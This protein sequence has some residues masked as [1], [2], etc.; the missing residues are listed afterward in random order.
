MLGKV[1]AEEKAKN[2]RKGRQE[3]LGS[4]GTEETIPGSKSRGIRGAG[5]PGANRRPLQR[6]WTT[7]RRAASTAIPLFALLKYRCPNARTL[8]VD[9]YRV[10]RVD[11]DLDGKNRAHLSGPLLRANYKRI[12]DER[13]REDELA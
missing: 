12:F 4:E 7:H 11:L 9:T 3:E 1:E 13:G 2:E 5:R 10:P 8:L 6:A